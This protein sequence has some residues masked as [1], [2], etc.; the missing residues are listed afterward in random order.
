MTIGA[1]PPPPGV[2]PNFENPESIAY[3]VMIIA[4]F[5]P[6]IAIPVCCVRI[7]T[8]R[9]ILQNLGFDDCEHVISI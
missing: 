4:V 7:Y 3:R 6:V 2:I 1:S 8:K 9:C 5:G